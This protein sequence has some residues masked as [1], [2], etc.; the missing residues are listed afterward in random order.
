MLYNRSPA[1]QFYSRAKWNYWL[2]DRARENH[3]FTYFVQCI[4]WASMTLKPMP[5]GVHMYDSSEIVGLLPKL[6]TI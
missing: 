1:S 6:Y 4:G 2:E 5:F 3:N